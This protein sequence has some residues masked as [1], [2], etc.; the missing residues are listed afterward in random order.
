MIRF[1][2]ARRRLLGLAV[3]S[4]A[5]L[6]AA[7][8]GDGTPQFQPLAAGQKYTQI[9]T[10][11]SSLSDTGNVCTATPASC[12]P[13]PYAPGVYSNGPIYLQNLGVNY[14][15]AVNPSLKGGTT[16]AYGGARIGA[17]PSP[18]SGAAA[19]TGTVPSM[20]QQLDTYLGSTGLRAD[21]NALYIV[22]A[23]GSFF[24]T[25]DA[26]SKAAGAAK[27]DAAQTAAYFNNV[28][29]A[30]ITD[31]IGMV[32]KLYF[33]GA[34]KVLVINAPNLG[35]TP[36]ATGDGVA[37]P[38]FSATNPPQPLNAAAFAMAV[39]KGFNDNLAAQFTGFK[40]SWAGLTLTV[41]DAFPVNYQAALN[42]ASF[43]LTNGTKACIT[44]PTCNPST[45]F[46]WDTVHPTAAV[47]KIF[48]S[49]IITL[50]GN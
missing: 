13:A 4:S 2:Q 39:S 14:K 30:S 49:Q 42:P 26:A 9:V 17:V 23:G 46:N 45:Y 41:Y 34:R 24:N 27:L 16:Y 11:G 40:P 31:V 22:E 3:A 6:L 38:Q 15:L 7:C 48:A 43:G 10:V 20:V 36:A 21:P 1:D 33:A 32:N 29:A 5:V 35:V 28:V 25:F 44:D 19:L 50:L 37:L 18:V 8:G 47:G 12:P